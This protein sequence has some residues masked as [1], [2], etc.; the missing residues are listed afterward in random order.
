M[1]SAAVP[2]RT[3]EGAE[4]TQ[5]RPSSGVESSRA[6]REDALSC[7]IS[8]RTR[9]AGSG[10]AG[11]TLYDQSCRNAS[12]GSAWS[13]PCYA[14]IATSHASRRSRAAP[15]P[16]HRSPARA[17][18]AV[19]AAGAGST[20]ASGW[21]LN[22]RTRSGAEARVAARAVNWTS[23]SRTPGPEPPGRAAGAVKCAR[24]GRR[25]GACVVRRVWRGELGTRRAERRRSRG[26][27]R[28]AR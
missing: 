27:P 21:P 20:G 6:R 1:R 9:W 28:L 11:S 16:R 4:R 25:G 24:V 17:T 26:S 2:R 19:R 14:S 8:C 7:V 13:S 18:A 5:G 10:G 12:V 15:A 23:V 22:V 3:Q